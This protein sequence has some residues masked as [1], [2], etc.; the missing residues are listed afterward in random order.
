M[1][2]TLKDRK[3]F[4]DSESVYI[5]TYKRSPGVKLGSN[6][7]IKVKLGGLV[8]MYPTCICIDSKFRQEFRFDIIKGQFRSSEVKLRSNLG[9]TRR[10]RV[11]LGR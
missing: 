9:Q 5:M 2:Y 10:I 8:E 7:R 11:K 4:T 6:R 1:T 3:F